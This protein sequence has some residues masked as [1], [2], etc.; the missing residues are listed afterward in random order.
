MIVKGTKQ[1]GN[2]KKGINLYIPKKRRVWR[3]LISDA[4]NTA[5]NGE[6]VW[7][8]VTLEGGKPRYDLVGGVV[9]DDNIFWIIGDEVWAISD[10]EAGLTYLSSDLITWELGPDGVEQVPT[11]TLYYTP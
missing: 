5:S 11:S 4:G 6:Y 3:I 2:F 1:L 9:G 10:Q 7:D 8:G